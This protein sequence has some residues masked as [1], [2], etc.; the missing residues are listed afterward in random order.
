[1]TPS[2]ASEVRHLPAEGPDLLDSSWPFLERGALDAIPDALMIIDLNNR[3]VRVNR[4]MAWRLQ[5]DPEE[6]R[7]R[8]F[9][10]LLHGRNAS[11]P[12][13]P[14]A[15]LLIDGKEHAAELTLHRLG[16]CL[17]TASPIHAAD[18][19]LA[20]SILVA[21]EIPGRD[22]QGK[23]DLRQGLVL[24]GTGNPE[25]LGI[26][27]G[28]IAHDF[29]NLLTTIQ[30]NAELARMDLPDDSPVRVNINEIDD[31]STRAAEICQLMLDYAGKG[32]LEVEPLDISEVV[33]GMRGGVETGAAGNLAFD[34]RLPEG[35]PGVAADPIQLRRL[36]RSLVTNAR[37]AIDQEAGVLTIRTG[38]L[39][40]GRSCSAD[41]RF[42]HELVEGRCVFLEVSDTGCGMDRKIMESLCDPY[43]STKF[44]GRGLSLSAALGIVRGHG[45][46]LRVWSEEGRGSTFLVLFPF[47][48]N[49]EQDKADGGDDDP[50]QWR[51]SG[52]VLIVDDEKPV[53]TVGRRMLER[54]GFDV[55]VAT[56]GREA[57]ETYQANAERIECVL[58]D[59]TMPEMDGEQAFR[60]M[61]KIRRDAVVILASGYS[62]EDVLGRFRGEGLAG[63]LHKPYRFNILRSMIRDVLES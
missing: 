11:P 34:Y 13:C 42:G 49:E 61:R 20:G 10:G 56:D 7:G 39:H 16:D 59:L 33:K 46:A 3:V 44:A 2:N 5:V 29:N 9:P 6:A 35:L 38:V 55:L 32:I 15:R 63:F 23:T 51:G 37:E 22:R 36:V 41:A 14:N 47:L 62:E 40:C 53:R 48:K 24:P 18:G 31:S 30:G 57:L 25:S 4:S 19:T 45:G 28:G 26:L 17:V 1:M 58:L 60:E 12:G 50:V 52:T 8:F 43:F 27:A 21:R 54:M